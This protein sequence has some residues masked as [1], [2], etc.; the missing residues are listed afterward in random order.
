MWTTRLIGETGISF[1]RV[2][3]YGRTG[4]KQDKGATKK[5]KINNPI[6]LA[7]NHNPPSFESPNYH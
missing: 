1:N 5:Q 7:T 3:F 4:I 6:R 2:R